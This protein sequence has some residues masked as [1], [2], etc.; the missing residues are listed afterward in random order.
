MNYSP[1]GGYSTTPR[2]RWGVYLL[3]LAA[4]TVFF[5][6]EFGRELYWGI[7]LG[8]GF[9]V[10]LFFGINWLVRNPERRSRLVPYAKWLILAGIIGN[11]LLF[12][13]KHFSP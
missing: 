10:F 4:I 8:T 12:I 11:I 13:W 7:P 2:W 5:G 3:A 9:L 6:H 1:Y